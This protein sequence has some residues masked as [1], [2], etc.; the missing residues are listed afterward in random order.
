MYTVIRFVA[1][2]QRSSQQLL[3]IGALLNESVTGA[4]DGLD[5]VGARFS[6]SVES[7]P[8]WP[9]HEEAICKFIRSASAAIAAAQANGIFV[10]IDVAVEP[11]D[12]SGSAYLS[13][14]P[15]MLLLK[16]LVDAGVSLGFT[17]CNPAP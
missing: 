13:L 3:S 11:E 15:S 10:E 8:A 2:S 5:R 17:F 1:D 6:V 7:S 9:A 4:Y 14:S 12:F 16:Q